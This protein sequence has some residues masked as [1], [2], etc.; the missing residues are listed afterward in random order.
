MRPEQAIG[1]EPGT[2]PGG[3]R[4]QERMEH[5]NVQTRIS[6]FKD[7]FVERKGGL[8]EKQVQRV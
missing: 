3:C 6:H 4:S 7:I 5:S 8:L 2:C 1:S